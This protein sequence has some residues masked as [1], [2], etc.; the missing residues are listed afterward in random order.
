MQESWQTTKPSFKLICNQNETSS[1]VISWQLSVRVQ[2]QKLFLIVSVQIIDKLFCGKAIRRHFS[3]SR[4]TKLSHTVFVYKLLELVV[5]D[6][7]KLLQQT[8]FRRIPS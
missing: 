3:S 7:V 8:N 6:V 2:L 4:F 1:D 5:V